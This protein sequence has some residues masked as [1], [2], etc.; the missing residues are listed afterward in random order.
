MPALAAPATLPAARLGATAAFFVT[1]AVFA[2]W[3]ARIP[4]VQERLGLAP[5]S[6]GVAFAALNAGAVLGLPA[7]AALVAR[8]GSRTALRIGFAVFPLALAAVAAAPSLTWLLPALVV[9]AAGNSVVDVGLNAQG[10]EL[11]RRAD[12]SLLSGLHAGHSFGVLAG[13]LAGTA[14]AAADL[15]VRV[16][17]GL[18]ALAGLLAGQAATRPLVSDRATGARRAWGWPGRRLLGL[19]GLA[20]LA[21]LAE[22]SA[23][24]WSA[25]HLRTERGAGPGLAAAAFTAFALALAAGRLAGDRLIG[26]WGRRRVVRSGGVVGTAG[27]GLFLT[28]PGA[29]AALA[30][31]AVLGLGLAVLA[32]ALLGAAANAGRGSPSSAIAAVTTAGYLGAFAGPAVI[33]ALAARAGL[34]AALGLVALACFL[35]AALAGRALP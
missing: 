13:G 27:A 11:E 1:G 8:A 10:V 3:A 25:V 12:R 26:R 33:G 22:G 17:L 7:G 23:N 28:L 35:V 16:H 19:G 5:A 32:P 21:F 18:G 4:A 34:T 14:A 30:G 29:G 20:F 6:L 2:T 24:D 31:W 15:D 9:M